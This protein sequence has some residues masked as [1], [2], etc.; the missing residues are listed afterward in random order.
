MKPKRLILVGLSFAMAL[1]VW[2][3]GQERSN[4]RNSIS[5]GDAGPAASGPRPVLR[6]DAKRRLEGQ[7]RFEANCGRCHMSPRKFPPRM[8]ATIIRHMR[9]RA[10]LTDEDMHLILEFMTE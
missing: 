5:G 3:A 9:V 1:A 7:K 4:G 10:T 2:A 8:M 6:S